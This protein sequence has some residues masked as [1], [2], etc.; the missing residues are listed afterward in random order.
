MLIRNAS[1][2]EGGRVDLRCVGGTITAIAPALPPLGGEMVIDAEGGAVLPG[3]HD[4]HM[5]L[6]AL[7]ASLASLDCGAAAN[8]ADLARLLGGASRSG[9]WLRA[10]NYHESIAGAIDRAWLDRVVPNAPIRVQHRSGRLW[11]LNSAAIA[12]VTHNGSATPLEQN[13]GV[14]TGRLYDGD[15]WLRARLGAALPDL[16]PVGRLL[17]QHGVTAVTDATPANDSAFFSVIS[18]AQ[19]RG[20]LPQR[21]A[22]MGTLNI[23]HAPRTNALFPLALKVHLHEGDY[24][25]PDVFMD[26]ARTAHAQGLGIAVHCVTEGD[27]VFT[28]SLLEESG[29][30]QHS[31]IEHASIVSPD[32]LPAL[33]TSGITIVTQPNFVSERGDAYRKDIPMAAHGHL[34]RCASLQ[35]AGVKLGGGTDAPFGHWNP[36]SAMQAAVT[37][38]TP[39]GET[40]G[41]DECLSPEA[42]LALFT[43]R[44]NDAGGIP[45]RVAVGEAADLCVLARPWSDAR[46]TLAAVTVRATVQGGRVI[47]QD[48]KKTNA[49]RKVA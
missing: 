9:Q 21:V 48:N 17:V 46:N 16:A 4:H 43:T 41:P 29:L 12:I 27:L 8:T 36:W 30:T 19:A 32:M 10:F 11:I 49:G 31:R 6:L 44:L 28:M 2:L 26:Q 42:A 38:R 34:Y 13:D 22:V 37:R 40:L 1:L 25:A 14:P 23:A 20:D 47:Y 7:A 39:C 33:A 15:H 3:L 24:P 5:H 45:R 18:D 35:A